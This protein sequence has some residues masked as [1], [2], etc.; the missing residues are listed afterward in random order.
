MLGLESCRSLLP[1]ALLVGTAQMQPQ[2]CQSQQNLGH[3][4]LAELWKGA[5]DARLLFFFSFLFNSIPILPRLR[6]AAFGGGGGSWW[7]W[8]GSASTW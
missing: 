4:V 6:A 7:G 2:G 5:S 1:P 8:V 3:E